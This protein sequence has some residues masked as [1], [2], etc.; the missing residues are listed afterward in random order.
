MVYDV[1]V[2][3]TLAFGSRGTVSGETKRSYRFNARAPYWIRLTDVSD[4]VL[5]TFPGSILALGFPAIGI[6]RFANIVPVLRQLGQPLKRS[7]FAAQG[8]R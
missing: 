7:C 6:L 3:A 1:N 4:D 2:K 8:L 5:E